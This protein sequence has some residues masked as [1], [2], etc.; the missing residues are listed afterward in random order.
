MFKLS[1]YKFSSID[2]DN[3][4]EKEN[5][6]FKKYNA[7]FKFNNRKV[8]SVTGEDAESFLQSMI[9]NDIKK[10][11]DDDVAMSSLFLTP[12]G[13]IQMDSII[14]KSHLYFMF[15]NLV[16]TKSIQNTGLMYTNRI[17]TN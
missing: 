16:L 4:I 10:L 15:F 8:V 5:I 1:S 3:D 13:R 14:V 12:K 9:S 11:K 6:I 17:K 2:S 7:V